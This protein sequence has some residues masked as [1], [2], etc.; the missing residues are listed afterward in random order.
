MVSIS[1]HL[2]YGRRKIIIGL[3]ASSQE[4][5][6]RRDN[7]WSLLKS[8]TRQLPTDPPFDIGTPK[9]PELAHLHTA[10]FAVSCH[11]LQRLGMNPQD[12]GGLIA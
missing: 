8:L 1:E 4:F 7:E 6:R 2:R 9:A 3:C 5:R 10:N 11:A 12:R